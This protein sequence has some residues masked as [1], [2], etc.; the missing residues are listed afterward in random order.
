VTSISIVKTRTP[1]NPVV[2]APVTYTIVVTNNGTA[3][4]GDLIVVDTVSPVIT[5][6]ATSQAPAFA[7]P[8]V[9]QVVS[10]TQYEWSAS[11]LNMTPGTSYTFTIDGTVGLVCASTPVDNTALAAVTS[12]CAMVTQLDTTSGF[13]V[14][15]VTDLT[16][17]KTQS[18]VSPS[19]GEP[20]TYSIVVTNTGVTTIND[21]IVVDTVSPVVTGVVLDQPAG[22]T[23]L[24]P[25]QVAGGT[26]Y[27][28][29]GSG[30]FMTPGVSFTFT[31]TGTVGSVSAPTTVNNAAWLSTS[32]VCG[33]IQIMTNAT[34][35]SL[36]P[37]VP[38]PVG[39]IG[40]GNMIIAP[41]TF[42]VSNPSGQVKFH[43]K[44]DPGGVA[45]VR[46]YNAAGQYMGTIP[47]PLNA[48]GV[49]VASY[50]LKG[51]DGY[52]PV[53]GAY[54]ALAQGGGVNDKQLFFI[55]SKKK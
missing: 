53:P 3:T 25:V 41:N 27:E 51:V 23:A 1:A 6:V 4:I 24:V 48:G 17:V 9:S 52:I 43:L 35:F 26:R 11:G 33:S 39:K 15:P 7:T 22:F 38:P 37:P 16:V 10:G 42:D 29:T 5:G 21:L 46:I 19:M 20:V 49:G 18:P 30:L 12:D 55:V 50:D 28:W 8:S 13:T 2:G 32:D 34:S 14:S 44:G 31:I 54:W 36:A 47:V 40:K 45:E